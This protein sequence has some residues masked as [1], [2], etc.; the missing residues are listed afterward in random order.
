MI[1]IF[2]P[3]CLSSRS[4]RRLVTP[5]K[6]DR[7]RAGQL[8]SFTIPALNGLGPRPIQQKTMFSPLVQTIQIWPE[9]LLCGFSSPTIKLSFFLEVFFYPLGYIAYNRKT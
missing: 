8:P 2:F 7:A 3:L 6:S 1:R 5:S 4:K 9:G